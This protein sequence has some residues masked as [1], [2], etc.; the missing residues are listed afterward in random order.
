LGG[1]G[2][3]PRTQQLRTELVAFVTAEAAKATDGERL[4]G[5][6]EVIE[7]IFGK[8]KRREG[9]Q[10]RSGVTGLVLALGAIVSH[11][12]AEVNRQTLENVPT[13][14]VLTWCREKLGKTVHATRRTL[15]ASPRNAEQKQAQTQLA[16]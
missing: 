16:A 13:K 1:G 6:S 7:S 14:A 3:L 5:S 2:T 11:T 15:F 8:W 4:V 12:S 9:E 10:A